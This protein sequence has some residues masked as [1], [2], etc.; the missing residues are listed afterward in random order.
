MDIPPIIK[1]ASPTSIVGL[2]D[3]KRELN[4][5]LS[6]GIELTLNFKGITFP[7]HHFST[8]L[9]HTL[10]VY[11]RDNYRVDLQLNQ[12]G[13][14]HVKDILGRSRSFVSIFTN[15]QTGKAQFDCRFRIWDVKSYVPYYIIIPHLSVYKFDMVME[16]KT[17]QKKGSKTYLEFHPIIGSDSEHYYTIGNHI[18]DIK[19]SQV[20]QFLEDTPVSISDYYPFYAPVCFQ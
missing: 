16:L 4:H 20:V 1:N 11:H 12:L 7:I 10:S 2:P 5:I 8:E 17:T 6:L 3:L 18:F 9:A 19:T 15:K 14:I 13:T